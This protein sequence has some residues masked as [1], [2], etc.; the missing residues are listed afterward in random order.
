VCGESDTGFLYFHENL[1]CPHPKKISELKSLGKCFP[2]YEIF[3][4]LDRERLITAVQENENVNLRKNR[5][6]KNKIL[7]YYGEM[8]QSL[9][10]FFTVVQELFP[11]LYHELFHEYKKAFG[12]SEQQLFLNYFK[13]SQNVMY[14]I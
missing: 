9:A 10:N 14:S 2:G 4:C 6:M 11:Y 3:S 12:D 8:I 7:P 13:V 5:S 1:H